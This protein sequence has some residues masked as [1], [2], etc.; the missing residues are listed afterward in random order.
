MPYNPVPVHLPPNYS[1]S[2]S[3]PP[4]YSLLCCL[5]HSSLTV[6]SINF[7]LLCSAFMDS[8]IALT[9][10]ID[11]INL[12]KFGG[13]NVETFQGQGHPRYSWNFLGLCLSGPT[14]SCT[15]WRTDDL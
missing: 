1:C 3:P 13:P 6:Y 15:P 12:P 9:I 10:A 5:A 7:Y 2:T 4:S 14:N 11:L 8:F